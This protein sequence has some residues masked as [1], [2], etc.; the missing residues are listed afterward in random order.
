MSPRPIRAEDAEALATI[1][2]TSFDPPWLAQDFA[3]FLGETG[4]GGLI[5]EGGFILVRAGGGELEVLTLA[6]SPS[7][8]RRGLARMLLEMALAKAAR[9]GAEAAFLEVAVDNIAAI[10]LYQ[11]A[12]FA[13][14][15]RRKGYYAR[16]E[17]GADALVLRRDLNSPPA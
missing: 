9:S 10:G 3:G 16:T 17:G 8:R 15:G 6:V 11:G 2:A 12:G 14:V 4:V 13:Q 5:G 7:N 1:H